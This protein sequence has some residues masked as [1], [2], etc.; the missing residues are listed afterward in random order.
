MNA[1]SNLLNMHCI[2][3][4]ALGANAVW[5][6]S[7]TPAT[8]VEGCLNSRPLTYRAST[9]EQLSTIRPIDFLE[10]EIHNLVTEV[11][12]H[13]KRRRSELPPVE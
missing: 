12:I 7:N 2:K 11:H 6:T 8:K 5:A 4:Y 1:I 3:P 9:M 13:G 10:R